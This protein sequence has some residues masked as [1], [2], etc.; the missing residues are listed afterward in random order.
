MPNIKVPF[1]G[2][3]R[4]YHSIKEEIDQAIRA[5]LESEAYVMGPTLARCCSR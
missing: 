3:A 5:V 4:Q 1:Y 2:H